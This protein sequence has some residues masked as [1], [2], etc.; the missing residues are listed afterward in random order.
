MLQVLGEPMRHTLLERLLA[1]PATATQLASE[2]D[3]TRSA[4]SQHLQ[5]MKAAGL[6]D[7]TAVGT[8]R[9]Y[10][11]DPGALAL[12]RDYFDSFWS[13]S[14]D[15]FADAARRAAAAPK[16]HSSKGQRRDR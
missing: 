15:N 6:V 5:V 4:I 13:R 11:V 1:E 12:L 10:A 16:P 8:R 7:D 2:L 14:L 9:V 3:V